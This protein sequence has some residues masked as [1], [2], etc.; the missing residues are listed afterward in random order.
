[1]CKMNES[2]VESVSNDTWEWYREVIRSWLEDPGVEQHE[3]LDMTVLKMDQA[4]AVGLADKN[5]GVYSV[6]DDCFRVRFILFYRC[7]LRSL[8]I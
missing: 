8:E 3:G 5:V 4:Y 1:M 6:S 2:L 7:S